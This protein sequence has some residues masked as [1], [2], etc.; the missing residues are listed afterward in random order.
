MDSLEGRRIVVTGGSRGLGL[1]LVE[2]LVERRAAVTAVARNSTRLAQLNKRLG[3]AVIAGD[4]TDPTLAQSVL[5]DVRPDVLVLNAGT[6]PPMGPLHEQAWE[7]FSATW[8]NDVKAGLHWIQAAIKMPLGRGS[9]VLITSSGAAVNGSPLSGGHAGAK[10]ML[11]LMAGYANGVSSELDLGIR[12]QVLI[13]RQIIGETDHGRH[14]A[15][16]YAKRKGITVETF[17]AG[18]GEPMPPRR[19]AEHVLTILTDPAHATGT[20]FALRG[21]TGIRSLD[22]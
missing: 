10:R 9:R 22:G 8:N 3:V 11:W 6:S 13:P 4:V 15:Q 16:A 18:F 19:F 1:G 17:L 12:F 2:A 20:A 5:N 7:E 21:D 14:A